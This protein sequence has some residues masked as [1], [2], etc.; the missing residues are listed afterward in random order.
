M[1]RE[2]QAPTV[3]NNGETDDTPG[4]GQGRPRRQ[5]RTG[6][7]RSGKMVMTEVF[8]PRVPPTK[9]REQPGQQDQHPGQHP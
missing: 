1:E 2:A 7:T 8:K 5:H 4:G 9:A 6:R 3:H